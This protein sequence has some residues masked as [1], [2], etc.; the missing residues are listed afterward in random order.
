MGYDLGRYYFFILF[1]I[2]FKFPLKY[3]FSNIHNLS[4][5]AAKNGET[6]NTLAAFAGGASAQILAN[7]PHSDSLGNFFNL[8]YFI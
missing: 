1:C 8:F 3:L 6:E 7:P 5:L 2:F 4:Y